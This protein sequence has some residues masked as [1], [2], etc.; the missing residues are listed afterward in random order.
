MGPRSCKHWPPYFPCSASPVKT[1]L[2]GPWR[3]VATDS[4]YRKKGCPFKQL[5]QQ[6]P[7]VKHRQ[8]NT[9]TFTP[10]PTPSGWVSNKTQLKEPAGLVFKESIAKSVTPRNCLWSLSNKLLLKEKSFLGPLVLTSYLY[11]DVSEICTR[12][13][14]KNSYNYK[15]NHVH[16]MGRMAMCWGRIPPST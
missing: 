10:L 2:K 11:Y 9:R 8:S 15:T 7:R 5:C 6:A 13:L 12:K 14:S 1:Q 3:T 4:L 16:L